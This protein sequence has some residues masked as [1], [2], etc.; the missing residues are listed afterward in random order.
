MK[1]LLTG[2]NGQIGWE[3]SNSLSK[4][5]T[6]FA[7]DRSEMDLSKLE[8]LGPIIQSI[9]PDIIINTAAYT[10]VDKAEVE[11]ELAMS[12]NGIAPGVIAEEAKKI[13]AVMIH[14]STDYIFNGKAT[15]PYKE[16]D[17]AYPLSIYGKSKLAG[18][19]AVIQAGI[20]HMILR[21]SW[22]YSLRGNNFLL[23][24]Q[25]LAQ[26]RKKINVVND[27][28]GGPTWAKSIAEGTARFL[29]Q[30][31]KTPRPHQAIIDS[32]IFHITCGGQT[33]WFD[34]A[35]T[36][37]KLSGLAEATELIPISTD[38]YITPATRP[39][40]SIL[41]NKKIKKTFD[42]EMPSWQEALQECLRS[43][44]K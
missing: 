41:S 38:N 31:L 6:V 15:S 3:L 10:A 20:P 29:E 42:Y 1:I 11:P 25:K 17:L 28:T 9:R 35:K 12:I 4:L 40:Y 22:V 26:S 13:G 5:G 30:N 8:M 23:T 36:I 21:T 19:K 33:N 7:L 43:A 44:L 39:K 18:E 32:G 14:Y 16:E 37:L 34:F 24:M 27:Q 2:K